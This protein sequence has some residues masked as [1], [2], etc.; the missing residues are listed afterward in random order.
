MI[1]TIILLLLL[2]AISTAQPDTSAAVKPEIYR[3]QIQDGSL[4]I[5]YI[6]SETDSL[7]RFETLSGI[8]VHLS[9]Y[10]QPWIREKE[11]YN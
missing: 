7:I 3:I 5:G 8:E 4:F 9:I 2:P 6:I 11:R 1:H 10:I